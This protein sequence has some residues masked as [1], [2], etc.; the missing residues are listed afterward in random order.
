MAADDTDAHAVTRAAIGGAVQEALPEIVG[1]C[2]A[3]LVPE[4][5]Q[6][7][8]HVMSQS[9][10]ASIISAVGTALTSMSSDRQRLRGAATILT[11]FKSISAAVNDGSSRRSDEFYESKGDKRS[12]GEE[13]FEGA[14]HTAAGTYEERKLGVIASLIANVDL[15]ESITGHE[16]QFALKT[17]DRLTFA[18]LCMLAKL[19]AKAPRPNEPIP[20]G[21]QSLVGQLEALADEGLVGIAQS[22]GRVAHYSA[23]YNG[24]TLRRG[25]ANVSLTAKG[26]RLALV[27]NLPLLAGSDDCGVIWEQLLAGQ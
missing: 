16:A 27:L 11:A 19:S 1:R 15:H 26:E 22:D 14:L 25:L 10:T 9:A 21:P 20:H 7:Y 13:L 3:G 5:F 23:V 8:V 24:G 18:Q 12:D 17:L 2:A 6:A 4:P